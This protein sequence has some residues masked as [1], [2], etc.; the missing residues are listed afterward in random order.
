MHAAFD[1]LGGEAIFKKPISTEG[2][3]IFVVRSRAEL[4]AV[5]D[6][7]PKLGGRLIAQPLVDSRIGADLEPGIMAKLDPSDVGRRHEFRVNTTRLPSGEI[8]IDAVY[9]RVAADEHQVVNNV[10]QGARA[11]PLA[12][13]DLHP[14]D[15]HTILEAARR[16]PPTGD[17]IGW[18]LIGQ[19]GTRLVIEG[20]SGSG[21]PSLK[22]GIDPRELTRAYGDVVRD[23]AERS[24][25]RAG[26]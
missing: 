15:Q 4:D 18:D 22:H 7:L 9:A 26:N 8:S 23:A 20:N 2:D 13:S 24:P 21:L 19:P 10:A 5:A 6:E 16:S 17:I 12:F 1:A 14:A 25:L 3:D 11:I